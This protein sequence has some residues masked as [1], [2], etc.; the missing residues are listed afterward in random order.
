MPYSRT[1]LLLLTDF[2]GFNFNLDSKRG[3]MRMQSTIRK[4]KKGWIERERED[5]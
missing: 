4:T 3:V 2:G 1:I 5:E